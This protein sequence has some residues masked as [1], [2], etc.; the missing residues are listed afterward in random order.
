MISIISSDNDIFDIEVTLKESYSLSIAKS[1]Y[2]VEN[3]IDI[4]DHA[5]RQLLK[6][7]YEGVT[8]DTPLNS[9]IP[10][11]ENE[12]KSYTAFIALLKYC[13]YDIENPSNIIPQIVSIVTDISV[14]INMMI[15]NITINKK[16][17]AINYTLDFEEFLF[18]D[19]LEFVEIRVNPTKAKN[20][21]KQNS[22]TKT[23]GEVSKT[24]ILLESTLHS[25]ILGKR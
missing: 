4:S 24:E 8:S 19:A 10:I 23:K 16:F 20:I 15:T 25:F 9:L 12:L 5:K 21:D 7:Q 22:K 11:S 6:I 14:F 13:G 1:Q 3:G 18:S 17:G 2:P